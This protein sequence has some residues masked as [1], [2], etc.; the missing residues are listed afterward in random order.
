MPKLTLHQTFSMLK[1]IFALT[2]EQKGWMITG[3]MV[4]VLFAIVGAWADL[5]LQYAI[6]N[7]A[8]KNPASTDSFADSAIK[9][10]MYFVVVLGLCELVFPNLQNALKVYL[11]NMVRMTVSVQVVRAMHRAKQQRGFS[12]DEYSQMWLQQLRDMI[13]NLVIVVF[14]APFYVRGYFV[15]GYFIL[16]L[17]GSVPMFVAA[18]LLGVYL[19]GAVTI[20]IGVHVSHMYRE[21]NEAFLALTDDEK[22]VF[23][24]LNEKADGS[25]LSW[26]VK[27]WALSN[28]KRDYRQMLKAWEIFLDAAISSELK[29]I[30]L[31]AGVRDLIFLATKI[32]T[33]LIAC[34]YV[35][36]GAIT[37]GTMLFLWGL[38]GKAAEP[39]S[40]LVPLQKQ[41]LEAQV[42]VNRFKTIVEFNKK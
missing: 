13:A 35:R 11:Q 1:F 32:I 41:L 5:P 22:A 14:D 21:K 18:S 10:A 20:W 36:E 3:V 4:S 34:W 7:L 23:G 29:L 26:F 25:I 17:W 15:H 9:T 31:G 28:V 6:D 40:L 30:A 24:L 38:I 2:S 37:V 27:G 33:I 19:Y 12:L 42:C 39:F 8:T 16:Y